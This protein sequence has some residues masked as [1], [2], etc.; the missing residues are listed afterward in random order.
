MMM[1]IDAQVSEERSM[2]Q[3][4]STSAHTHTQIDVSPKCQTKA[5][6]KGRLHGGVHTWVRAKGRAQWD[7]GQDRFLIRRMDEEEEDA[8]KTCVGRGDMN[9]RRIR[10]GSSEVRGQRS[11]V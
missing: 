8:G 11:A 3:L 2:E 9:V 10:E 1:R 6:V 7:A 4:Q 5:E